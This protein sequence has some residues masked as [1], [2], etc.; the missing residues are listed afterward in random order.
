MIDLPKY[1]RH[2]FLPIFLTGLYGL[3]GQNLVKNPNFDVYK[4]CPKRLG[5]FGVDVKHWTSPTKGTTDYFNSCSEVMDVADNFIGKQ[6]PKLGNGYAGM[7]VY[8]PDDYREYIQVALTETLIK[9]R[10]Y[11][12]SF[13]ISRAEESDFAVR[14]FG[15]LLTQK[16][17]RIPMD[18]ALTRWQ[19]S[20]FKDNPYHLEEI[21]N[22]TFHTS[23]SKWTLISTE[24]IAKGGENFLTI[25]NFRSNA[26]TPKKQMRDDSKKGGYYYVDAVQLE[27]MAMEVPQ[28]LVNGNNEN[29]T[30]DKTHI[31]ENVL[32]PFDGFQLMDKAKKELMMVYMYLASDTSLNIT[33]NGHTDAIGKTGYNKKL[34][35]KRAK[36]VKEYLV[37]LGLSSDRIISYGYGGEQPVKENA[38]PEGRKQNRRVEFIITQK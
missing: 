25:G 17:M 22:A 16:K 13:Y 35:M 26:K 14:D 12:F 27:V 1:I 23:T 8:G 19:L 37:S 18:K 6:V 30:L 28:D 36:A 15:V 29:Y 38:T 20:K 33:I 4:N 3:L 11:L 2:I 5:T 24:I 9:G 34:S 21:R 32:F 10:K 31:F 7:Y